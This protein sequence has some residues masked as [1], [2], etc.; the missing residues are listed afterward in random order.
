MFMC[1]CCQPHLPVLWTPASLTLS[2]HVGAVAGVGHTGGTSCSGRFFP[3]AVAYEGE[4]VVHPPLTGWIS[5]L[6]GGVEVKK[7]LSV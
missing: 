6:G 7:D 1:V 3:P 2:V 5:R 4:G